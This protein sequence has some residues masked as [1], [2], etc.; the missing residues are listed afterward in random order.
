MIQIIAEIATGSNLHWWCSFSETIS[1][2]SHWTKF[3][4]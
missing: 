2:P 1:I 4:V 3:E